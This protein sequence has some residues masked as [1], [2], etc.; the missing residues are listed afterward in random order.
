MVFQNY[1]LY[2]HM[3][4]RQNMGFSLKMS[5]ETPSKIETLVQKVAQPL[6]LAKYL[7]RSPRQ[8]SGG[9]RQRAAMGRAIIRNPKAFLFDEP[10]SNLDA[11]F[12]VQVRTELKA[13]HQRLRTTSLYVTHDQVEAMTLADRIAVMRD[14]TIQQV[15][16]PLE[17]YDRP[18]NL[19]VAGFIGSPAMN[20]LHG[21]LCR[22]GDQASIRLPDGTR[23]PLPHSTEGESGRPVVYGCRPEHLTLA[24]DGIPAE[25]C[26]IEPTGADTY[27]YAR[28]AKAKVCVAVRNADAQRSASAYASP[29]TPRRS[30]FSIPKAEGLSEVESFR[31]NQGKVTPDVASRDSILARGH[32]P[33]GDD[34][35]RSERRDRLLGIARADRL[36]G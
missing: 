3:T 25:V 20:L 36:H 21:E 17:L 27:V 31:A 30:M 6:D 1:A 13:L 10:L 15:G 4:V 12:R 24:A 28:I 32:P 2:P 16:R 26:V 35:V 14:G 8:L 22:N 9:Q 5:G 7:D 19:F 34:A 29:R 18:A 11:Q 23:L 33:A